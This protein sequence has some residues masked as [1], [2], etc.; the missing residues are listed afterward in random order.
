MLKNRIHPG[1]FLQEELAERGLSQA[2]LASHIGVAPGVINVICNGKRG[3]SPA[4]AKRLAIALGTS[5]E[6]WMNLQTSY[7]LSRAAEP[8]FGRLRA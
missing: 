5:P 8:S 2:R 4:M 1:D 6:L 7:D 3:I